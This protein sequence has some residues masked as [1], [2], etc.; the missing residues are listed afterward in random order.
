M[1]TN[2]NNDSSNNKIIIGFSFPN[3]T[4]FMQKWKTADNADEH[5]FNRNS[6]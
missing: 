5:D 6:C 2:Q 3:A 4:L 1:S